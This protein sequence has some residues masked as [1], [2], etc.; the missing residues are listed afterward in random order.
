METLTSEVS[1]TMLDLLTVVMTMLHACTFYPN[2][3]DQTLRKVA[4]IWK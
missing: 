2:F 3:S 1:G 4:S